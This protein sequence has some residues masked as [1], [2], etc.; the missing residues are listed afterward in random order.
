MITETAG[1]NGTADGLAPGDAIPDHLRL[2]LYMNP[3]IACVAPSGCSVDVDNVQ[4]V[5]PKSA[6]SR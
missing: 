2:G 4:V 1:V 5:A 6:K 3:S